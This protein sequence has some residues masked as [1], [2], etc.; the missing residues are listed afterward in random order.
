MI[1]TLN[2]VMIKSTFQPRA[3]A[4]PVPGELAAGAAADVRA[5]CDYLGRVP[6]PHRVLALGQ[7]GLSGQ[8][9]LI[10]SDPA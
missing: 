7:T 9:S 1:E 3:P 8:W 10:S 6:H 2:I 5:G 4:H